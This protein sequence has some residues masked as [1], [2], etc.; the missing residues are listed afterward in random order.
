MSYLPLSDHKAATYWALN[1]IEHKRQRGQIGPQ[2]FPEYYRA[3]TTLSVGRCEMLIEYKSGQLSLTVYPP[4][5]T[6]LKKPVNVDMSKVI[7]FPSVTAP[8][9]PGNLDMPTHYRIAEKLVKHGKAVPVHLWG[10][11]EAHIEGGYET[12]P[13]LNAILEGDLIEAARICDTETKAALADI[14]TFLADWAPERCFGSPK[15]V[16]D[17]RQSRGQHRA[18][19]ER[20]LEAAE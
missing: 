5:L 10:S 15:A 6:G 8:T 7:T 3:H 2:S 4:A 18:S 9:L 17:W 12:S 16:E 19:A 20:R 13:S 11:L 1:I 14:V